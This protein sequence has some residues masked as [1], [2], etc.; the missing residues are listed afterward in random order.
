MG[1]RICFFIVILVVSILGLKAQEYHGI[2]GLLQTP[3]AEADSAGTFRGNISWI[4]KRM[5]PDMSYY[6]DGIPFSAPCYSI[7]FSAWSWLQLSYTETMVKTH[8]SK[9]KDAPLGYN[10]EDRHINIKL[11][12]LKEGKWWPAIALGWDDIGSL[13]SLKLDKGMTTN[14]FFENMYIA[15][16]KYFD[17]KGYELGTHLA[18][19]YYPNDKNRE[20]R[21]LAGGL[22]LRPTFYKELKLITE[23][24]GIG[25]NAGADVLLWR[26]LFAQVALVHGK[27]FSGGLGYR[28]QIRF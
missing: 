23:W 16:S 24:D 22:T 28:Y 25:V 20:R 8:G 15:A 14:N 3:S 19:R 11:I 1:K 27:G 21:G 4:D 13:K 10:N 18:Y 26:H 7:G 6:G 12:P 2:T 17:I 9:G 5:L